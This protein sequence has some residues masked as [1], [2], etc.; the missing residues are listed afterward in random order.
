M[1]DNIEDFEEFSKIVR[2]R[3]AYDISELK[4][5]FEKKPLIILFKH[6]YTF[7]ADVTRKDMLEAGIFG[8][9]QSIRTISKEQFEKL[10]K[11]DSMIASNVF[12]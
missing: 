7:S 12:M 9:V 2:K 1:Y 6:Y 8:N 5:L 10:L 4:K 3:T 11:K